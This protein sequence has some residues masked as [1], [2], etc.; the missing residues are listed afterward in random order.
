MG[1]LFIKTPAITPITVIRLTINT[2]TR[3]GGSFPRTV[4][5]RKKVTTEQ[6]MP[7]NNEEISA[8]ELLAKTKYM[9]K[10][11]PVTKAKILKNI[12][13]EKVI[14]TVISIGVNLL[15]IALATIE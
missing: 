6:I 13:P 1:S 12:P 3:A 5:N 4:L 11:E 7:K 10:S 15:E 8:I 9:P 2:D 14:I